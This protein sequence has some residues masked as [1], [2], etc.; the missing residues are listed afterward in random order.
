MYKFYG[1]LTMRSIIFMTISFK[2]FNFTIQSSETLMATSL[3][4]RKRCFTN[5]N[6]KSN[7][8]NPPQ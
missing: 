7:K 5:Y 3:K 4:I 8:N 6:T 1:K 2:I